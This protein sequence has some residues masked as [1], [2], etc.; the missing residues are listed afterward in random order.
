MAAIKKE[1]LNVQI[2]LQK[3]QHEVLLEIYES[4]LNYQKDLKNITEVY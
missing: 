2:A 4:E 3:K 1:K